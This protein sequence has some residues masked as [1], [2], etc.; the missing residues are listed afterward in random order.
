MTL[1]SGVISSLGR[2]NQWQEAQRFPADLVGAQPLGVG[3]AERSALWAVRDPVR[4]PT[5]E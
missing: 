1:A 5:K 4:N 3:V 2:P